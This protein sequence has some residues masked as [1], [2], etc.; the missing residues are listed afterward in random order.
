ML[1][2]LLKKLKSVVDWGG[3]VWT[4]LGWL[5][6]ASIVTGLLASAGGAVW[7][8]IAGVPVP[9]A[10]MAGYCTFVAA[11]YLALAPLIFR[12]L[13][14][15]QTVP[16]PPETRKVEPDWEIWWQRQFL[17]LRQA[18]MLWCECD[19]NV[20]VKGEIAREV[21]ARLDLLKDAVKAGALKIRH[22]GNIPYMDHSGDDQDCRRQALHEYAKT[23]QSKPRFLFG[24]APL[25][26]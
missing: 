17:T 23:Q 6:L 4:V 19:P 12:S 9:I 2:G 13:R 16:A 5:G 25:V 10:L 24:S 11:A 22:P 3:T 7:A 14:R 26:S 1:G 21:Y 18:A 15:V 8:V 20:D